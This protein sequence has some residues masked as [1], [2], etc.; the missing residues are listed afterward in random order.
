MPASA[1]FSTRMLQEARRAGVGVGPQLGHRLQLQLGVA[2]AA[3][4]HR[5]AERVRAGFH[6]RAGRASG[7][8]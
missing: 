6:H 7:G 8:S 4:E 2:D 3:G 5:A 1:A